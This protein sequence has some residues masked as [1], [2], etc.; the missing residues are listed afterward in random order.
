MHVYHK[1]Y[2]IVLG[3]VLFFF[4]GCGQQTSQSRYPIVSATKLLLSIEAFPN[5][6]E[7]NPCTPHCDRSEQFGEA[8]RSFIRPHVAGHVIQHVTNYVYERS[9]HGEFQRALEV[10]FPEPAPDEPP[11]NAAPPISYMSPIAD[12]Y[13]FGCGIDVVSACRVLARYSNYYVEI[14]FDIDGGDGDGLEIRE[15]QPILEALDTLIAT[16]LGINMP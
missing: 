5:S 14:Y 12:D 11:F 16:Q 8:R 2:Y 1:K 7:I 3:L 9:A 13:H 6:W 15:V 10:T 4:I